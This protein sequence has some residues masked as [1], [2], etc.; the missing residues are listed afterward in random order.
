[1]ILSI[2]IATTV[3]RKHLFD[4]L[5]K[6]FTRQIT[7]FEGSVEIISRSDNKEMSIGR[8]RQLLL[9]ESRGEYIVYFDDDDMPRK[10]YVSSIM[11]ALE[12]KPDCVGFKIHMTTNGL[13]PQTCI[14]SLSNPKWEFKN[15]VYL[16]NC[17]HFNPVKRE[18]AI[19]VGFNDI[20]FGEDKEYSDRV[21][22][23]CKKEIF[24]NKYLFD[25]RYSTKQEHKQ[26][27]GI[28]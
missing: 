16:R 9:E 14:H 12:C 15:G 6:E 5:I 19:K 26:K 10:D 11:L 25:Y 24:V 17:T 21:S 20:R 23:L 3:E 1:M 4:E 2:L 18:I 28:Q 27:Y 8:K 13:N 22:T 7:A